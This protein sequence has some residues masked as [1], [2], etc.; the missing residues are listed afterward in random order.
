LEAKARGGDITFWIGAFVMKTATKVQKLVLERRKLLANE[1]TLRP[2]SRGS[3]SNNNEIIII[4]KKKKKR[5]KLQV[6]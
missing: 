4:I 2:N 1:F 6:S 5:F 3:T